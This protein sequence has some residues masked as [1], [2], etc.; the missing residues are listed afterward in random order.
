VPLSIWLGLEDCLRAVTERRPQAILDSGIGF[1]TFGQLFRQYLDVWEGRVAREDWRVRIDG[2]ELVAERVQPHQRHVYDRV[3]IGDIRRLVPELAAATDYDVILFG[4]VLEHL[5]KDDA[6]ELLR[7]AVTLARD[8]VLVRIPLGDGW[9]RRGR[10]PADDH[11]SRW[12]LDDFAGY[13][14]TFAQ[15]DYLGNAYG[16]LAID[17]P[18]SRAFA[19]G[20]AENRLRAVEERIAALERPC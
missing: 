17:A 14:G 20:R 12:R 18:R 19:V 4:D 16:Q 2:V 9:R 7:V 15:Y 8:L 5:P 6:V 3:E 10:I 13:V 1:G 11:L